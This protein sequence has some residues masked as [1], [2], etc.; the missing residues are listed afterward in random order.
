[1]TFLGNPACYDH[2]VKV[3][4]GELFNRSIIGVIIIIMGEMCFHARMHTGWLVG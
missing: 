2:K 3:M 1:M 4:K